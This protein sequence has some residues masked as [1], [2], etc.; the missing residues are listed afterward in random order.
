MT[1]AAAGSTAT[2]A[3]SSLI[4][5]RTTFRLAGVVYD[6][7]ETAFNKLIV[8]QVTADV[9]AA[10]AA[11]GNFAVSVGAA[12]SRQRAA[13]DFQVT[14]DYYDAAEADTV[15]AELTKGGV[16]YKVSVTVEG[17]P[18]SYL[19]AS[20]DTVTVTAS[21]AAP[22]P[23]AAA[24]SAPLAAAAPASWLAAAVAA[25]LYLAN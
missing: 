15:E 7:A 10:G 18:I 23:P 8:D 4:A 13:G 25:A 24:S 22:T 19:A 2:A 6:A 11:A 5:K 21:T 9:I 17:V 1:T 12:T 3:G 20:R 16:V 14:I